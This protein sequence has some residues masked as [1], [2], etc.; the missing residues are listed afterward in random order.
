M[1]QMDSLVTDLI[2]KS[3]STLDQAA[4]LEG[5]GGKEI[6][7]KWKVL[8]PDMLDPRVEMEMSPSMPFRGRGE[9]RLML[10]D[11]A[12]AP[13]REKPDM[14]TPIPI[15]LRAAKEELIAI[16]EKLP[17]RLGRLFALGS[18]GDAVL[19]ARSARDFR[20]LALMP[21]ALDP[22]VD[23]DGK[24]R[25][26]QLSQK[27]FEAKITAYDKRLDEVDEDDIIASITAALPGGP[28]PGVTFER[29]GDLL[30]IDALEADGT[31]LQK[32]SLALE[33]RLAAWDRFSMIPGAPQPKRSI[34]PTVNGSNGVVRPS[35]AL[36]PE[37]TKPVVK[38]PPLKIAEV[39]GQVVLLFPAERF[40]LD[41]AAA[42]GKRDWDAVVQSIDGLSGSQRDR[43]QRDGGGF[44]APLEFLSE[45]FVDGKPLSKP[46]FEKDAVAL[47][48]G[49]RTLAVHF[50]RFGP[51]AI[52]ELPGKGRFVTS[53]L[54][55]PNEA[56]ALLK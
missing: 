4:L 7:A 2:F 29:R 6:I 50:P 1:L 17:V 54:E 28:P 52:L 24:R 19:V 14:A 45:V 12:G 31:W 53:L 40:D 43:L 46:A 27:E 8:D 35:A 39:S 15:D 44:V 34:S 36:A 25:G 38:G 32:N 42:I 11:E 30:I 23:I 18:W 56:A 16:C 51:V 13:M 21:W 33:D 26:T 10:I 37:V 3:N 9:R 20:A 47:S 5:L 48:S 22:N 41:V 55:A 49:G